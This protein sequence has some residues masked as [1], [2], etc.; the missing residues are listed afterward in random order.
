MPFEGI[1]R[2]TRVESARQDRR[3][4]EQ[5]RREMASPET[6]ADGGR[7]RAHEDVV[8]AQMADVDREAVEM[9]PAQ[10]VVDDDL[11]QPGRSRGRVEER[12][13]AGRQGA[14][15]ELAGEDVAVGGPALGRRLAA[16]RDRI[17]G[18]AIPF[19]DDMMLDPDAALAQ[20]GDPARRGAVRHLRGG[21]QD[22]RGGEGQQMGELALAAARGEAEADEAAALGGLIGDVEGR[23]VGH[24]D[25]DAFA[26]LEAE[27]EED[28]REAIGGRVV[29]RPVE[30]RPST[31]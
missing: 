29:A 14:R 21:D 24:P 30:T 23:A 7:Q 5:R 9:E 22:S 17:L 6:E 12:D 2:R 25:G 3:R 20:A 13:V 11:G 18:E 4:A 16:E 27:G 8:L 19:E 26:G 15:G 1:D 10:L 28:A 31:T